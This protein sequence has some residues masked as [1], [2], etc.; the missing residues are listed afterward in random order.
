MTMVDVL[1]VLFRCLGVTDPVLI[2]EDLI[3]RELVTWGHVVRYRQV[4]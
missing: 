1:T 2:M 3:P 4:G